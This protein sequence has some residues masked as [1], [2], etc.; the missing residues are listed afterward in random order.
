MI[1][2]LI[3]LAAMGVWFLVWHLTDGDRLMTGRVKALWL[4]FL[5]APFFLLVNAVLVGM[6][7]TVGESDYEPI[8]LSGVP[9]AL[10]S[11]SSSCVTSRTQ[12]CSW[13]FSCASRASW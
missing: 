7:D 4:P 12:L 11:V 10:R 5:L 8:R 13:D 6:H 2:A 1:A 9:T 3:Y